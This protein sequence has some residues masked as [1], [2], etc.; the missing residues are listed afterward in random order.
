M[1]HD[2]VKPNKKWLDFWGIWLMCHNLYKFLDFKG[3][4]LYNI[5]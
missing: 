2:Y 1:L 5:E 3:G 4:I